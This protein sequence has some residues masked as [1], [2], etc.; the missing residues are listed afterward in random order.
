MRSVLEFLQNTE[1]L[2][3]DTENIARAMYASATVTRLKSYR[4]RLKSYFNEHPDDVA[5]INTLLEQTNSQAM[6]LE[7]YLSRVDSKYYDKRK[8]RLSV[9]MLC[10]A[11]KKV[12][13]DVTNNPDKMDEY[14]LPYFVELNNYIYHLYADSLFYVWDVTE[15]DMLKI[16]E[17]K[18]FLEEYDHGCYIDIACN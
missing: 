16:K 8:L 13:L 3:N 15:A 1:A 2:V 10:K 9:E 14:Q 6:Q 17:M 5:G 4:A 12:M 18:I 11:S 7:F